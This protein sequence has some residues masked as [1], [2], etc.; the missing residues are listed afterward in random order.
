[1]LH[2]VNGDSVANKLKQGNVQGDILVWREIY[3]VGPVFRDM[4]EPGNRAARAAY[5]EQALG[6]PQAA[7]L[8]SLDEQQQ[9][10]QQFRKHS[11]VVLW[12]EHDLFDQSMLSYLLHWFARQQPLGGTALQ[13]IVIGSY[14]GIELFRGLG[15]LTGEQLT[16]LAGMR[17]PAG[18]LELESG[19]RLWEAYSSPDPQRHLKLLHEERDALSALP[20]AREAFE[21]HL[22]RLPAIRNGLGIVEQATLAYLSEVGG[23][24]APFE[25]F[26]QT[27]DS[28]HVLGLGDL[29][30]WHRLSRMAGGAYP[31]V[32]VDSTAAE[33]VSYPS[34][35]DPAPSFRDCRV[36]ITELGRQ[37]LAGEADW[38]AMQGI[39]EWVGGLRLQGRNTLCRWDAAQKTMIL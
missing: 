6:I 3:T 29:E 12:F 32:R 21:A 23:V 26:R 37:V 35:S 28:L 16:S 19:A 18:T 1:M 2:I 11:E 4:D 33:L 38:A 27:S 31:L 36:S 20:Y 5:L 13:L 34:F 8:D 17:Q 9:R 39:E 7:Y 24:T 25:L 22:S 10:L 30:Y 14:P 15:Q